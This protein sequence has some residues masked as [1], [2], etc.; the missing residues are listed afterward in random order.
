MRIFHWNYVLWWTD[1]EP[2]L[3][4]N[5]MQIGPGPCSRRVQTA[6]NYQSVSTLHHCA[7][8]TAVEMHC[9]GSFLLTYS[10]LYVGFSPR[11]HKQ[12]VYTRLRWRAHVCAA[13]HRFLLHCAL[14]AAQCIV[15]GPVC[16]WVG[17]PVSE[18]TYIVSSGTLNSSIPYH[19]PLCVCMC[20][21]VCVWVGL[22]PWSLEIAYI[23]P[24]QTAFVCKGSD[25]LQ[26]IKFWPSRTREGVCGGAKIFGSALLQPACGVCVSSERFFH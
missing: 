16:L 19:I 14:A 18:M 12:C 8:L 17:R 2:N 5:S 7:S 23:D 9:G 11:C 10:Y 24:H 25:H 22:L 26:L 6:R 4:S 3:V 13:V 20:V 1:S 15:I 21:C